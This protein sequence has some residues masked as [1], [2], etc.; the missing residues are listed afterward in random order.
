MSEKLVK[1]SFFS[2]FLPLIASLFLPADW[3]RNLVRR[4]RPELSFPERSMKLASFQGGDAAETLRLSRLSGEQEPL[5]SDCSEA[6]PDDAPSLPIITPPSFFAVTCTYVDTQPRT[7]CV[8]SHRRCASLHAHVC[9]KKKKKKRKC[10]FKCVWEWES[11]ICL[12]PPAN[13]LPVSV[14]RLEARCA[15]THARTLSHPPT[16]THA[17]TA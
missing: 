17:H 16:H 10:A 8:F 12:C 3:S 15:R 14:C 11:C 2:S 7:P 1:D 6:R 5:Q 9:E 4:A 13:I